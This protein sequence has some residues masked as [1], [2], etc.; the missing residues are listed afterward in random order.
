[1]EVSKILKYI[2]FEELLT[3]YKNLKKIEKVMG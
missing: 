3:F 1:M 2:V